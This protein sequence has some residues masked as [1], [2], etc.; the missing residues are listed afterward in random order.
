MKIIFLGG[1][2]G[3][4]KT[5]MAYKL[6]LKYKIDKVISLD[7]LK[8]IIKMTNNDI[9][10]NTTTH[11][12]YKIE[13]L[14]IISGFLKHAEV[15]NKEYV[16]Y[17]KQFYYE[18]II[19]VEGA[20]ITKEF[21]NFFKNDECLYINLYLEKKKDLVKRYEKKLKM[22][23]GNWMK[24]IDN[25]LVINNYLKKQAKINIKNF[26]EMEKYLNESLFL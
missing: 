22:R 20:T 26:K 16:K 24:N 18:N 25:I 19:I 7:I 4:G 8:T 11:E 6:A 5:T 10:I 2:P 13:N 9:Y 3:V 1:I 23:Q 12:A 15:I 17:I 21:L 14:D